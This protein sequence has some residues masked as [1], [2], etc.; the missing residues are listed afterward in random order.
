M[1]AT[2][3]NGKQGGVTRSFGDVVSDVTTLAELQWQLLKVDC[4]DTAKRVKLPVVLLVVGGLLVAGCCPVLWLL[5]AAACYEYGQLS[6]TVSLAIGSGAGLVISLILLFIAKS[7]LGTAVASFERSNM[8]LKRNVEWLKNLK[9]R[10]QRESE[11]EANM[12]RR[13]SLN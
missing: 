5:I 4:A 10:A 13:N 7:Q 6:L 8:E 9:R 3:Q 12:A 2:S 1:S 11:R